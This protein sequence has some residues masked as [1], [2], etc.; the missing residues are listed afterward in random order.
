MDS[1]PRHIGIERSL[2][3]RIVRALRTALRHVLLGLA[4]AW[5]AGALYFSN[6]PW[7]WAR[8]ALAIAFAAFAIWALWISRRT[9]A[10]AAFAVIFIAVL[11]WWTSIPPSH[12]REWR[13]EVAVMPRARIEGDHVELTGVRNFEYA[14]ERDFTPHYETR[15]VE[16]SHLTGADFYISYWMPGPVGHTFLSFTFDNAPPVSISIE[17]RPEA[18]EGFSPLGSLFKQFELIYVVGDER[19]IVGVRTN[20][21]G[22]DVYLYRIASSPEHARALFLIYLARINALADHP[23]HYHLLSNNCTINIVRYTRAAG[24]PLA[25]D[26]RHYLNGLADRYLY[27]LGVLNSSLPFDELRRR[28][29]INDVAQAS[30]GDPAFAARI[31]DALPTQRDR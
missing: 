14:S 17:A 16:L 25:F 21:R 18:H 20:H 30:D 8:S 12:D 26:V 13:A 7:A 11:A 29:H 28:S 5:G 1:T 24:R 3:W 19:D 27:D 9:R 15:H 31:R 2:P 23:E 4:V 10:I 22:E 6:L